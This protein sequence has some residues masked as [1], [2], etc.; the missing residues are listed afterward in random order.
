MTSLL[1]PE[2]A[3]LEP[4]ARPW[5]LETQDERHGKRLASSR[6][7]MREFYDAITPLMPKIL[8]MVD[9]HS[10]G[11]LPAELRCLYNLALSLAEIAPHIEL[12]RGDPKVPHSFEETRF[13]AE[14]GK[15]V[16]WRAELPN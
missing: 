9:R 15:R 2:F 8:E 13:M 11:A 5:G 3:V 12:Y 1:P 14:H 4:F 7:E 10:L 6:E 16:T